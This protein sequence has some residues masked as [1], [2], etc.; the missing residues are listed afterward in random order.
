MG[1]WFAH[2]LARRR[3]LADQVHLDRVAFV[4]AETQAHVLSV[5]CNEVEHGG[6]GSVW[7]DIALTKGQ[8]R[9]K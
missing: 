3:Q 1:L 7:L 9:Q 5:V 6:I 8:W 2:R 4:L